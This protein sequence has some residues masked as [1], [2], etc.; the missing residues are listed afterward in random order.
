LA[1]N[2]NVNDF[3]NISNIDYVFDKDPKRHRDAKK[4]EKISWQQYRRMVGRKWTAGMNVPF[5][6]VAA[7]AAQKYGMK[8]SIIGKDLKNRRFRDIVTV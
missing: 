5:D 7:K 6:P 3:I 2:L 4:I 8:V 1:K